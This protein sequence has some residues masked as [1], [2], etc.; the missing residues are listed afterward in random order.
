[1]TNPELVEVKLIG[2]PLDLQRIASEHQDGLKREFAFLA[3]QQAP[4]AVPS[5]LLSLTQELNVRFQS[6]SAGPTAELEAAMATDQT[7]FD[8]TFLIPPAAGPACAQFA[9]LLDEADAYCLA[10]KDLLTLVAPDEVIDYRNWFL[11]EF[12]RQISG[13]PALPWPTYR[14]QLSS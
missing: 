10:G 3:E 12:V 2:I 14:E 9:N 4:D 5:R 1:M 8:L 11:Y 13:E 7:A 6:F